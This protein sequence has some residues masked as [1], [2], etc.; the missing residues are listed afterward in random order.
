MKTV[1]KSIRQQLKRAQGP[2]A[3]SGC[4][5]VVGRA[6]SANTVCNYADN[7]YGDQACRSLN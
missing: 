7:Y 5:G 4:S 2:K 1:L 3:Q 6:P